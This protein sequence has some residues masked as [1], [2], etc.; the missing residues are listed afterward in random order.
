MTDS[1]ETCQSCQRSPGEVGPVVAVVDTYV[2]NDLQN[3]ERV[4]GDCARFY[5]GTGGANYAR[6]VTW[7]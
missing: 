3:S 5:E 2:Q 1:V 4:C 7:L 6:V